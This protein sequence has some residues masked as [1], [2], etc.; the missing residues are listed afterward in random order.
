MKELLNSNHLLDVP[1]KASLVRF[2]SHLHVIERLW[3][4]GNYDCKKGQLT[5]HLDQ[6]L[7]P[8]WKLRDPNAWKVTKPSNF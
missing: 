5:L 2:A 4:G 6:P 7:R 8:S 3:N 1:K